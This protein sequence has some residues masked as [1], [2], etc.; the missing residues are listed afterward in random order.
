MHGDLGALL[1]KLKWMPRQVRGHKMA[2]VGAMKWGFGG[3]FW[4]EAIG[5]PLHGTIH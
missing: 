5:D 2:R 3:G 4:G 1:Y